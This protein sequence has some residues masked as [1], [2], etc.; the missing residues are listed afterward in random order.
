MDCLKIELKRFL[1]G[2]K[3]LLRSQVFAKNLYCFTQYGRGRG[4][5]KTPQI[6]I[7][8]SLSHNLDLYQ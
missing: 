6:K 5:V 3:L 2:E 4:V 7:S 1:Q 8:P